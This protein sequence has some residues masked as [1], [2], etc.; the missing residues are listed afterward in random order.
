[1]DLETGSFDYSSEHENNFNE[2]GF[3]LLN[4]G[5][6]KLATICWFTCSYQN[7]PKED[8]IA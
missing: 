7:S 1:M 8:P 6:I 3:N 2:L 5:N 4:G